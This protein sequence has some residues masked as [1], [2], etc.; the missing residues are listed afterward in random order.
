[1]EVEIASG[2]SVGDFLLR[3]RRG[4]SETSDDAGKKTTRFFEYVAYKKRWEGQGFNESTLKNLGPYGLLARRYIGERIPDLRIRPCEQRV[5]CSCEA[6]LVGE[7]PRKGRG[8]LSFTFD[9]NQEGVS[10][11][12]IYMKYD[13]IDGSVTAAGHEKW[14]ELQSAQFGVGRGITM[15]TGRGANREASA[16]SVSEVVVT[17]MTDASSPKLFGASLHGEGKKVTIDFCKTDEG[18]LETY[19]QLEL[20]NTLVSSFNVSSGG[21]RPMESLSLNFLSVLFKHTPQKGE[22]APDS[23][24]TVGYD[25]ATAKVM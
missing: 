21:D 22:N 4:G 8:R 9:P 25:L 6:P 13:G 17:K 7:P 2:R 18:Q 16:P 15:P 20:E 23:P 5:F 10:E 1:V 14:I 11:M 3:S 24:E 12:P 19:L